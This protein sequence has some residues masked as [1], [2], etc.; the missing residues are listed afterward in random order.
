M[1]FF[2]LHFDS[3][4]LTYRQ[5]DEHM[6]TEKRRRKSQEQL[7][8]RHCQSVFVKGVKG[9]IERPRLAVVYV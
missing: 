1:T 2:Q 7:H 3:A 6:S 8:A 4:E 9:A 5:K